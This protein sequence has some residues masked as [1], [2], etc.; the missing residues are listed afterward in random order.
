MLFFKY[1]FKSFPEVPALELFVCAVCAQLPFEQT[2][3][4]VP[5]LHFMTG[6]S[7]TP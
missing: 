4:C 7:T 5:N 3:H 6:T 1:H 2:Q